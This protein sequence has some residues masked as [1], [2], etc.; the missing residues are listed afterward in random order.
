[1][2]ETDLFDDAD[3]AELQQPELYDNAG[4][5]P[6]TAEQHA[7]LKR[8]GSLKA[9]LAVNAVRLEQV[10]KWGHTDES[11]AD[12][13]VWWHAKQ[14]EARIHDAVEIL[15]T[16]DPDRFTTAHKK[17]LKGL[18]LGLTALDRIDAVIAA[19]Q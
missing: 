5:P 1:M 8:L 2:P 6:Y 9:V 4:S 3:A 15:R 11:D 16:G 13:P 17:L 12:Q 10:T 7:T 14:A 19:Q 18:A